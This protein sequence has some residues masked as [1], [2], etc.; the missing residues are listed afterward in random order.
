MIIWRLVARFAGLDEVVVAD[1][2][3]AFEYDLFNVTPPVHA[4]A[5][6]QVFARTG[7][8]DHMRMWQQV[9]GTL[10]AH[11]R[12]AQLPGGRGRAHRGPREPLGIHADPAIGR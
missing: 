4:W 3:G 8:N 10:L 11:L 7:G 6:W 1:L 12:F 5:C 9:S 2:L